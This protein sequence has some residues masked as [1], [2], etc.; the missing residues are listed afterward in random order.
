MTI[1][2]LAERLQAME[3]MNRK[4][5]S[6][7]EHS[8]REH[9]AEIRRLN[10][11]LDELSGR[12]PSVSAEDGEPAGAASLGPAPTPDEEARRRLTGPV[13]SYATQPIEFDVPSTADGLDAA[14]GR[15][16]RGRLNQGFQ[17]ETP[18]EEF[19]LQ[20]HIQSQ[21]ESRIW[22]ESNQT[23]V[24][25]GFYYPRQ[26]IFFNGR[27]TRPL[28]YVFSINRGFG[29]LN[30]LE[31]Y[32]NF[33]P[34]DR[35]QVRL[36]RYM[37]PLTYD[38]FAIRNIWLPT[39]ER[40]LF[41][42]NVGLNRQIGLMAWG[43][44]LDRRLDYAAGVFTGPRN[45]FEDFNN[46]KDFIGFLN[47]RPFQNSTRWEFLRDWNIG[48]SVAF[49]VQNQPAV[50]QAFRIGAVAP[51]NASQAALA[52]P[53]FLTL[54]N[55]V[56]ERGDRLLGS[57]HSAFYRKGLSLIG[58]WQY[59]SAGYASPNR[60][61]PLAVPISG[62]YATAAYFLTG[63]H[64]ERRAM[65]KP[66]RP[67][68]PTSKDQDRGLGAWELV[69]RYSALG[70]GEQIFRAGFADPN[71]WS[72]QAATT[73]VGLNWYLNEY[74]KVYM[75]WLHGEFGDPVLYRPGGFQKNADLFWLR[76]QLYF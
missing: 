54:N 29:E 22:G 49:G 47:A 7:L 42:T 34:N 57:V 40:S 41:T 67:V 27:I 66:L 5:A 20:V 52:A 53:P 71:L 26:R 28:E 58:E 4:L 37:T 70:F 55:G 44:V 35:F 51:T 72:N 69:G 15:G 19:L 3:A 2:Q 38:Q 50:P 59:G 39:P 21:I 16:L 30:I 25:D 12:P 48:S 64:V 75:F 9:Q 33:H 24:A 23:P 56:V 18:D 32:L 60:P 36:G 11:K 17:F 61:N 14:A 74:M 62:F 65:V 68:F 43:T 73:E 10:E 31:S 76:F 1:E 46:E 63:E 45:S 6:E 8:S 13:P